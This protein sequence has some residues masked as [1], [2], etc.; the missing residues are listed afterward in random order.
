[1]GGAGPTGQVVDGSKWIELPAFK[2]GFGFG[3]S[4]LTLL[5]VPGASDS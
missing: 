3:P 1:M 4:L 2:Q 5:F